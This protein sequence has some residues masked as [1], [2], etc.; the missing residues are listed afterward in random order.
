VFVASILYGF[1]MLRRKD[2]G[3]RRALGASRLLII[4]LILLQMLYLGTLGAALGSVTAATALVLTGAP[5]PGLDFIAAVA[6]LACAVAVSA[7]A[8]PAVIAS[9]RDPIRELRV[10]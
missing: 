4:G 7:A 2:Y 5:V 6:V 9:R 1:T 8:V 3:R 10:P